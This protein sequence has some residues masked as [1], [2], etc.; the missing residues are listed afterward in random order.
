MFLVTKLLKM[1]PTHILRCNSVDVISVPEQEI[2]IYTQ[3]ARG[4]GYENWIVV[5]IICLE[6]IIIPDV[7]R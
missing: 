3:I 1:I 7:K 5:E 4:V 2:K 6:W